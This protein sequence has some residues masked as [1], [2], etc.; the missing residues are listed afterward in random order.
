MFGHFLDMLKKKIFVVAFDF[1]MFQYKIK[2]FLLLENF[3]FDIS[4]TL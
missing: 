2:E 4:L 3:M 1:Q